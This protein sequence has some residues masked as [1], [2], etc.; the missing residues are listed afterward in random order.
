MRL[1]I[2]GAADGSVL[3]RHSRRIATFA[4]PPEPDRLLVMTA[5][6][7]IA[8]LRQLS[9]MDGTVRWKKVLQYHGGITRMELS[10]DGRTLGTVG[11]WE[12]M[13]IDV[14]TL[15]VRFPQRMKSDEARP[16]A[17]AFSPDGGT[18]VFAERTTLHVV[19]VR[20]IEPR[21][22]TRFDG[23]TVRDIAFRG[24]GQAL[25]IVRGTA[26]VEER[27]ARSWVVA[28]AYDWNA[29]KLSCLTLSPDGTLACAGSDSGKVVVWDVDL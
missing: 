14:G 11:A 16:A 1:V 15:K 5:S 23:P 19:D 2:L 25:F 29:G 22:G 24:D 27:D 6:M 4:V 21:P 13:L 12:A 17:L 18:F 8:E 20:A 7:D 9:L 26:T 3:A 28:R 10:P